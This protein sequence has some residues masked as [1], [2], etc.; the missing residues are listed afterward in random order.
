MIKTRHIKVAEH[1]EV[2]GE[3]EA[4]RS[5]GLQNFRSVDNIRAVVV[6]RLKSLGNMGRG[7][8]QLLKLISSVRRITSANKRDRGMLRFLLLSY[9]GQDIT[10]CIMILGVVSSKFLRT[11]LNRQE[12]DL[13]SEPYRACQL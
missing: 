2:C 1:K 9:L 3:H 11:V 12:I 6:A 5:S 7:L 13:V 8:R 10:S 4:S